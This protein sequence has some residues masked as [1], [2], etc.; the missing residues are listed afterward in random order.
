[1]DFETMIK[2]IK[3]GRKMKRAGWNGAFIFYDRCANCISLMTKI[4]IKTQFFISNTDMLASDWMEHVDIQVAP[5]FA[6]TYGAKC[7]SCGKVFIL[8]ASWKTKTGDKIR[9]SC[10]CTMLLAPPDDCKTC[11]EE[12]KKEK[13]YKWPEA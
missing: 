9:C 4:G 10:G 13:D 11:K 2:E 6:S 3:A 5:M 12:K 7:P 1:M 8:G